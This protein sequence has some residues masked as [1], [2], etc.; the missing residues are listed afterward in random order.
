MSHQF[1]LDAPRS[2]QVS[3]RDPAAP[4]ALDLLGVL[5]RVRQ[6]TAC[7]WRTAVSPV[8]TM[9]HF[10]VLQAVSARPRGS[11]ND[12]CDAL[13]AS[14]SAVTHLL[15]RAVL[16]RRGAAHADRRCR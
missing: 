5:R 8:I 6:N 7:Q 3:F 9:T 14:P 1:A 10:L 16:E 4:G 2:E 12:L 15:T 13:G 11:Q